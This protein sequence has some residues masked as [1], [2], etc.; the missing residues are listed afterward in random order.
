MGT[1]T[2]TP[3][4]VLTA[5]PGRNDRGNA[6]R[7][8]ASGSPPTRAARAPALAATAADQSACPTNPICAAT[9]TAS[10]RKGTTATASIEAVPSSLRFELPVV[11]GATPA[12]VSGRGARVARSNEQFGHD[13]ASRQ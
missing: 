10:S 1:C 3:S 13:S 5:D 9:R 7:A 8:E 4:S 12:T 11:G 2:D 6:R